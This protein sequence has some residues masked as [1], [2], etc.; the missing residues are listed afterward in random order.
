MLRNSKGKW[1]PHCNDVKWQGKSSPKIFQKERR[2]NKT[3]MKA[4]KNQ[5]DKQLQSKYRR[6]RVTGLVMKNPIA[7]A[8]MRFWI[9]RSNG[10]NIEGLDCSEHYIHSRSGGPDIRI[11]ILK[12]LNNQGRLPCMLFVHGGGYMLGNPE[13][14]FN[15]I[16]QLIDTR[17]CVVVVPD[18]RKSIKWPYPAGFN[19][20]YDTLLWIKENAATLGV[21]PGQ[22]IVAGQSA[23]GG[24]TAAVT[25]K[26]R[27]TGEVNI[28][29]QMPLYPMIDDR[30]VTGSARQMNLYPWTSEL[31]GK[32]WDR[33]LK[34]LKHKNEDIPA[35]AAPARAENYTGL[36]PTITFVGELEPFRDETIAYVEVLKKAGVRVEFELYK[37]CFHAFDLIAPD[38]DVSKK[39]DRFLM[40]A[41]G[42]Y[43]DNYFKEV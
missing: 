38:A 16:K 6:L 11:R 15:S 5:L 31:N 43:Y 39:A 14:A 41:Y 4:G 40:T 24:L 18:Y 3:T 9:K 10:K 33:Y 35:Y 2:F 23:G 17:A 26:A 25:L 30:Q 13:S 29:F 32:A 37:G 7:L 42:K 21:Y 20:C 1:L 28:A 34:D 12:P 22:L 8:L 36:P 27:D 19:D